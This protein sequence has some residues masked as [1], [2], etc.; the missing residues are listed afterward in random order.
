MGIALLGWIATLT[1]CFQV[2][3]GRYR[4]ENLIRFLFEKE[5]L[6]FKLAFAL[7]HTIQIAIIKL[8]CPTLTNVE[9]YIFIIRNHYYDRFSY[10]VPNS[11]FIEDIGVTAS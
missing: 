10:S 3:S 1:H 7:C 11:E 8:Y 9:R 4:R 2:N 5:N 6:L